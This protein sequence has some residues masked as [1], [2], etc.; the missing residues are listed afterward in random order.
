ML[1]KLIADT[2]AEVQPSYAVTPGKEGI[3]IPAHTTMNLGEKT[4]VFIV[5]NIV[6]TAPVMAYKKYKML[7][8]GFSSIRFGR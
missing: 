3:V 7:S 4:V 8:T 2:V 5:T 6:L 1:E